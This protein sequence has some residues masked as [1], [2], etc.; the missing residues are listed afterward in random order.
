MNDLRRKQLEQVMEQIEGA[1]QLLVDVICDET[2]FQDENQY[3]FE[4]PSMASQLRQVMECLNMANKSLVEGHIYIKSAIE[5]S[6][7]E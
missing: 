2:L 1:T 6:K 3:L 4:L 7:G 5:K